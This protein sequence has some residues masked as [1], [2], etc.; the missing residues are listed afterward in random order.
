MIPAPHKTPETL[1]SQYAILMRSILT[2]TGGIG[3][4]VGVGVGIWRDM[5]LSGIF[6]RGACLCVAFAFLSRFLAMGLFRAH[7]EQLT[8]ARKI[9]EMLKNKETPKS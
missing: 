6:L 9:A 7:V 2:I 5:P 4:A 3:F 1:S 8:A